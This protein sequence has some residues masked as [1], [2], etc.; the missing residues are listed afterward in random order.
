LP[1]HPFTAVSEFILTDIQ[2]ARLWTAKP[3]PQFAD[4]PQALLGVMQRT[5]LRFQ[6]VNLTPFQATSLYEAFVIEGQQFR[7]R[8]APYLAHDAYKDVNEDIKVMLESM[9]SKNA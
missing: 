6:D 7:E 8:Y 5:L 4:D 9:K 2:T 1:P 3:G